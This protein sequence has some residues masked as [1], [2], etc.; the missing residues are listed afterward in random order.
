MW[1]SESPNGRPSK[2][3]AMAR[4][5]RVFKNIP[6]HKVTPVIP[7]ACCRLEISVERVCLSPSVTRQQNKAL[8][9]AKD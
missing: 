4:R 9:A 6:L 1:R 3:A 5:G 2:D 7:V 8:S